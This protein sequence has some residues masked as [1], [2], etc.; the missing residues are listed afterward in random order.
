MCWTLPPLEF[1]GQGA[2]VFHIHVCNFYHLPLWLSKSCLQT[3]HS[4]ENEDWTG[5]LATPLDLGVSFSK[6]TTITK[7]F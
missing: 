5:V 1:K 7:H 2:E 3:L 6:P 4:E